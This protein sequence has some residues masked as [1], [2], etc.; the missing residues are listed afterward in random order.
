MFIDNMYLFTDSNVKKKHNFQCIEQLF[1]ACRV[2]SFLFSVLC[3][4][5]QRLSHGMDGA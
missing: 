4:L 1:Y 2:R 5:C 3:V